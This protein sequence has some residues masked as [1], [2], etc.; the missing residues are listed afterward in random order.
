[1]TG[2]ITEDQYASY[3]DFIAVIRNA[4]QMPILISQTAVIGGTG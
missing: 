3:S 4:L 2:F 1:M